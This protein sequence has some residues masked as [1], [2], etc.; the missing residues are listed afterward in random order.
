MTERSAGILL[1]PTSL[2]GNFGIGDL[3]PEAYNFLNF[4]ESA[5][6]RLWQVFP[7]GP[8]GYG[9][10]P[11]QTF[12]A[13]AG[14]PLLISPELLHQENLLTKEEISN[15]PHFDRT[16]IDYGWVID[17]KYSLLKKAYENFK[18]HKE[19]FQKEYDEFCKE[20]KAWLDD[21]ALFMAIKDAHGGVA[22]TD[23]QEDIKL[24]KESAIKEW[25]EK[26]ADSIE[27][28]KFIQHIFFKQWHK[29][30][31]Y[32][33]SKNIKIIGDLPIFIAYDSVDLWANQNLFSVDKNGNLISVA[34]VP[35]DYF[36]ATG[37]LW[38][39]PL[40][41]WD[42][43]GKDEYKW[44]RMRIENLLELVD[45]IRIDHFR[46]FDAYW[47]IPAGSP[48]A[49]TGRWVK[50][51]GH[52]FF[53]AVKKHLGDLPI[54]AE[55]LGVITK[56]VEKLRDDFNLPGIKILQF[57]FGTG[58]E[59]KFLPHNVIKNCIVHTGSH[60]NDTTR[61]YFEKAKEDKNS[62]IFEFTKNY[63]DY[64]GDDAAIINEKLIKAAYMTVA[65]MVVIPMQDVL[66]M[67]SEARMNYPGKLGGNWTWRFTWEQI[68]H[69]LASRYKNYTILYDRPPKPKKDVEIETDEA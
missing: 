11:Y 58:M 5:G 17:Y 66:N 32:A 43:M 45:I 63:L 33:H 1:H 49:E 37:Q 23:W 59:N 34:G 38:G 2:P 25:T 55:D 18:N 22:W 54:I 12:S 28:R 26:L 29:L 30:K 19:K 69:D 10:S 7:L 46:G 62:D 40:Y 48:T 41:K 57:A 50:G 27:F 52:K 14:N 44:W 42:E 60:D 39:N 47:E 9:D 8:T 67:G 3:G 24:R 6:Q 4:L 53:N 61:G 20:H 31:D 51:P 64:F 13:F 65:D 68:S 16:H 36:S 15:P 21:Y 56:S 35:P